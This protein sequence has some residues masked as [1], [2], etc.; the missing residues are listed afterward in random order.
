M[1]QVIRPPDGVVV[2]C[3]WVGLLVSQVVGQGPGQ[4]F[5]APPGADQ[6]IGLLVSRPRHGLELSVISKAGRC[7][8]PVMFAEAMFFRL[9]WGESWAA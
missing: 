5:T 6:Q 4:V 1:Y 8:T 7:Q 9:G 3:S 2:G